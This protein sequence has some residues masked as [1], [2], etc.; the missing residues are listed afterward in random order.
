MKLKK[1]IVTSLMV[2]GTVIAISGCMGTQKGEALSV[3]EYQ[4]E[5]KD[6]FTEIQKITEN[7]DTNTEEGIH[8]LVS[9]ITPLYD[10]IK[11]LNPPD[12][13]K[14]AHK[15]LVNGC[16]ASSEILTLSEEVIRGLANDDGTG[17]DNLSKLQ[18]K[19]DA[20]ST[21]KEEMESA[22]NEIYGLTDT[23]STSD[24]KK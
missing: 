4:S 8:Q 20:Y 13:Y 2:I 7:S 12:E 9:E 23:S 16:N 1:L 24:A 15:K 22:V 10:Q 14:E 11:A 17:S 19:I 6:I 21:V 3:S 5:V 18:E